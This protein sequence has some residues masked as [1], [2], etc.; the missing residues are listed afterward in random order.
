MNNFE[1]VVFGKLPNVSG[2]SQKELPANL[3][4]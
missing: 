2:F 3:Y 1:E 4:I